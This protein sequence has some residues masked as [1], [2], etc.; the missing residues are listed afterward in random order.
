MTPTEYSLVTW[1]RREHAR[2]TRLLREGKG[3]ID[4][5]VPEYRVTWTEVCAKAEELGLEPYKDILGFRLWWDEARK[6]KEPSK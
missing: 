1:A 5:I 3:Q 6:F 2:R 4:W